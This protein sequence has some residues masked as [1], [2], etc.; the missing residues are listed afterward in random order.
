MRGR[1]R[2]PDNA[3]VPVSPGRPPMPRDLP[4]AGKRLWG[5]V[6]DHLPVDVLSLL[7]GAALEGMCR[8]FAEYKAL[9]TDKAMDRGQRVRAAANAW[10][11]FF[12]AAKAFGLTPAD[13]GRLKGTAPEPEAKE[14]ILK[15]VG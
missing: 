10:R 7:D 2:K 9:A 3:R 13:R 6:C 1:P 14:D 12:D 15:Y 5:D 11:Q 4:A 8:W